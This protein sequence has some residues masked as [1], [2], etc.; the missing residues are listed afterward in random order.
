M[1]KST[2][3]F[4]RRV[5]TAH[6]LIETAL[7]AFVDPVG[8]VNF[9]RA[10]D[11]QADEK[12]IFLEKGAHLVVELGAVG[13]H[14]V[15]EALVGPSVFLG[16]LHRLLKKL[17]AHQGRLAALPGDGDFR[18]LVTFE[19]LLE[20]SLQQLIRHAKAAAGIEHLLR[21]EEAVLAVEIADRARRLGKNMKRRRRVL[22]Q[23]QPARTARRRIIEFRHCDDLWFDTAVSALPIKQKQTE[24]TEFR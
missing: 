11:A 7:A 14:G 13:L 1:L 16:V 22:R 15:L 8:V 19:Q 2:L 18:S 3:C 10:V 21:K 20:V 12:I 6:D 9:S 5:Q 17:Q 23:C 24:K 4:F